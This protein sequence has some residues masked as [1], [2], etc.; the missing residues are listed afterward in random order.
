[1]I[2]VRD[3]TVVYDRQPI[4]TNLSVQFE[5]NAITGIIGPN[6]AGKSTMIKGILGLIN[7]QNGIVTMHGKP[8]EQ[9]LK[10]IAYVEQR[11]NLDLSFPINVFDTVLT[12][13]YPNLGLFNIPDI[14]EKN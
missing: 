6:G 1:M 14:K 3:M 7:K 2:K 13:T 12:G 11:A 5:P 4:F 8:I 9:Q 10:K